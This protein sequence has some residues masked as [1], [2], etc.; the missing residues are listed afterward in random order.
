MIPTISYS[1]K[2]AP[3]DKT[4]AACMAKV[5]YRE[6]IGSLMYT[7]VATRPDIS[8]TVSTLSQFLENPG[9]AHWEAVKRVF[10][11]L[12]GMRDLALTYGGDWHEL[13][14]YTDADRSSQHHR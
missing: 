3:T 7:S 8:F 10:R 13:T 14:G 6:A 5:P 9:E 12:A 4:D 2:D 11:Y 1:T